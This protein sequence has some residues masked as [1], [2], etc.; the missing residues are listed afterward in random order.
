MTRL[1]QAGGLSRRRFLG[2]SL[3]TGAA[4]L[5]LGNWPGIAG[6]SV[7]DGKLRV[8]LY[9]DIANLDPAFWTS[10]NDAVVMELIYAYAM[11]Y[12]PN[13]GTFEA[14]PMALKSV[15]VRD[16]THIDFELNS[17][18]RYSG[19]YGEMTAEDAKFSWERI[20][21]PA[22]ASPYAADW[23]QLDHV[24]VTGP[25]TGTIV[26]KAPFAPLFTSTLPATSGIILPRAAIEAAGGAFTTEPPVTSGPY[27][28]KEWTPRTK[29]VLEKNPDFA[30][31]PV[32]FDV[33]ELIP[34]E[35][36]KTGELGFEAGDLD[37]CETSISSIPRYADAAPNG[38][39]FEQ[40]TALS[41]YWLGLNEGNTVLSDQRIRRAIQ[42]GISREMVVEA[43]YLGAA[44]PSAGI[45][46][47]G[48]LGHREANLY[49]YD[50]EAARALL[51]EAGATGVKITLAIQQTAE[52][53]AAAQV[54]QAM[55]ADIG[56]ELQI[57]QHESGTFWS[58]GVE[59]DGDSWKDLQLF[60]FSFTMQPDPSWATMWFTTDQVGIWNWQRFSNAEFDQL[61]ADAVTEMDTAKRAEMYVKMQDILE[62]SGDVV[63]LTYEPVGALSVQGVV[64]AMR[65]DGWPMLAHFKRG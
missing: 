37:H 53:L 33:I 21:D 11:A 28:I 24:E 44:Q 29:V 39:K 10:G 9:A 8:R 54:I 63:Y 61:N 45:I 1:T 34:I 59:A 42:L 64:P 35:D 12:T 46:A 41:Y 17:G 47:P 18:I 62:E 60:L 65:P 19:E 2:T 22:T 49:N 50:P 27:R 38:A 36:P 5:T 23:A 51:A 43:A 31:F 3:A 15:T 6:A 32:D 25:L 48:L 20:A 26:L 4:A 56:I 52:D 40:Y 57:D 7:Q 55:L 13:S 58:L 16:A 14:K 30:L